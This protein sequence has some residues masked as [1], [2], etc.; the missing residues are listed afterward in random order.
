[1]FIFSKVL[2]QL[3]LVTFLKGALQVLRQLLTTEISLKMIK[4]A[5]Y[6]TFYLSSFSSQNI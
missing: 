4:I 1:M 3:I 2:D 5:F 6:F